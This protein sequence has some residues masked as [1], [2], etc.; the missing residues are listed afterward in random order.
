MNF[1]L[2]RGLTR[3]QRHWASFLP[4]LTKKI[5]GAQIFC[6]DFPGTGTE[7]KRKSPR[8]VGEIR[9][10]LQKRFETLPKNG[11]PWVLVTTSLGS[12]VGLDW[13]SNSPET[14][15]KLVLMNPSARNVGKPWDRFN[16]KFLP[17]IAKVLL[18]F[19]PEISEPVVL[20]LTSNRVP[21]LQDYL[22]QMIEFQKK[23]PVSRQ[24]FL[25]QLVAGIKFKLPTKV[26]VPTLLCY[27]KQDRLVSP[28]CSEKIAKIL[29]IEIRG[30][31]LAGHDL[32]LDAPDWLAL[33]IAD[34]TKNS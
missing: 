14:F 32:P 7:Y 1:L 28:K 10:D 24:T 34:F 25:N 30:H 11:Q 5:P 31:M 20:D 33:Q 22:K 21:D 23:A 15:Q 26:T 29:N 2:L 9:A 12:M 13:V 6:L 18:N 8:S 3:D 4:E 27:S 16:P 19:K 17:R